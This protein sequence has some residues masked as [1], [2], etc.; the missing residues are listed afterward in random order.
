MDRHFSLRRRK[1][2]KRWAEKCKDYIRNFLAF[3]FSN[4]GIIGLVVGY[5]VAGA[6]IFIHIE[7]DQEDI[8]RRTISQQRNIKADTIW[9]ITNFTNIFPENERLWRTSVMRELEE[10]Q[11]A[12]IDA[13]KHG[14]DGCDTIGT[15]TLWSFPGA[16]L[17][18]LTVITTIGYG[19]VVPQ[20]KLGKVITIIYAIIGMPLFLLYLSNIGD[21][22]AR[23]FKWLYA[24]ICLCRCCPGVAKKRAERR[25]RRAEELSVDYYGNRNGSESPEVS[26]RRGQFQETSGS[27]EEQSENGTDN[28]DSQTVTVPVTICL[29]IMLHTRRNGPLREV[30][31]QMDDARRFLFLLHFAEH[32]RIRRPR[33]RQG[34]LLRHQVRA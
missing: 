23:S 20:T 31:G 18:S 29:V 16:F 34:D 33:A 7:G 26:I 17:Y 14:F 11:V 12:I 25:R 15:N 24:K 3:M 5:T 13:V 10:Y 30:R 32:N 19:N 28:S 8:L 21:I 2:R 22:M 4:I 9:N 1:Y 6:F 27:S